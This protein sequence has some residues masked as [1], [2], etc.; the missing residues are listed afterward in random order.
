MAG[1]FLAFKSQLVSP[2]HEDPSRTSATLPQH[3]VSVS[4]TLTSKLIEFW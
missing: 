4:S 3:S 2:P 1:S